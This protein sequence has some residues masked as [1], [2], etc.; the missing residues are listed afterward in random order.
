MKF[1]KSCSLYYLHRSIYCCPSCQKNPSC[2]Q[3][4]SSSFR[5][6]EFVLYIE[7]YCK[8]E[9]IR[10][11][12][13]WWMVILSWLFNLR[14]VSRSF[15]GLRLWLVISVQCNSCWS[16]LSRCFQHSFC[17]CVNVTSTNKHDLTISE[18]KIMLH[19]KAAC[20]FLVCSSYMRA[21]R[22]SSFR[23]TQMSEILVS[24][25]YS[26]NLFNNS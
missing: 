23:C 13:L 7:E 21:D 3:H 4:A 2:Q 16:M 24:N 10:C 6:D 26:F 15:S 22:S 17:W 9:Q 19:L 12:Y 8:V 11:N 14:R 25:F 1:F 18:L 5:H 20:N